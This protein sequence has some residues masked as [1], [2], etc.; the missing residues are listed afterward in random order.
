MWFSFAASFGLSCSFF[1][2]I[3]LL[4]GGRHAGQQLRRPGYTPSPGGEIAPVEVHDARR[5]MG[6]WHGAGR[7]GRCSALTVDAYIHTKSPR[8]GEMMWKRTACR[9]AGDRIRERQYVRSTVCVCPSKE[10]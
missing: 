3:H 1:L 2:V 5:R 8:P 9:C 4:G 7:R 6:C 10:G